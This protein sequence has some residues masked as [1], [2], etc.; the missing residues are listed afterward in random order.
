MRT[1]IL[2]CL[3]ATCSVGIASAQP[4]EAPARLLAGRD[5]FN[6]QHAAD[7]Q[8]RPDGGAVAYVRVS[9]DIMH[10]RAVHSIWVVDVA[11]GEETPVAATDGD[12]RSPRW[13]PDGRRLAYVSGSAGGRAQIYVRRMD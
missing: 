13:S 5:L 12:Q 2:A 4:P 6:L 7:P 1:V 8:I 3:A 9:Y 10:D 11:T